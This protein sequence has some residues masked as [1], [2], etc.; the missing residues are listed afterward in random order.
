MD[1]RDC[2]VDFVLMH[3]DIAVAKVVMDF[4]TG[5]L[6]TLKEV[7]NKEH[8]PLIVGDYKEEDKEACVSAL[9]YWWEDIRCIPNGRQGFSEVKKLIGK[10]NIWFSI[11]ETHGM[12]LTDHY[13][14]REKSENIKY[15]NVNFFRNDRQ[16]GEVSGL[17][18]ILLG[19]SAEIKD[20]DWATPSI[21]LNGILRKK[22]VRDSSNFNHI[23]LV[24]AGS[25]KSGQDA[26]NEEVAS[27]VARRLG[28]NAVNYKTDIQDGGNLVCT[29]CDCFTDEHSE[30]I[31][32][33]EICMRTDRRNGETDAEW[34]IRGCE[35][36]GIPREAVLQ[37]FGQTFVLDSII[38]NIDRHF[39]N[40]GFMRDPDT[41]E[42]IGP[43]KIFDSG[44]SLW[45]DSDF[46]Q[47]G[48]YNSFERETYDDENGN[49]VMKDQILYP[50]AKPFAGEQGEQLRK[51]KKVGVRF[52]DYFNKRFLSGID[53]EADI[54]LK[55][56]RLSDKRHS[57]VVHG[58]K[59][60]VG[61]TEKAINSKD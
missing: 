50:N 57:A 6:I 20:N 15:R 30:F 46:K 35:K 61:L 56:A 41:L 11:Y 2:F 47:P 1:R 54:I 42:F 18:D 26:V 39:Q 34:I 23:Y 40:M 60:R 53:E 45:Y 52:N 21:M 17:S 44:A 10:N 59:R 13:W 24:K 8:L 36:A 22:W 51:L 25:G 9:K 55:N 38:A 14:I 48:G 12:T 27:A 43:A 3:K 37:L 28:F 7:Y 31:T 58:I 4:D 49:P 5:K 32:I 33:D 16:N 19:K 29:K